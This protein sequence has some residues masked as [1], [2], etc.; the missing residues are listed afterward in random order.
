MGC[1][2]DTWRRRIETRDGFLFPLKELPIAG[3]VCSIYRASQCPV[4]LENL[5]VTL[6]PSA[7]SIRSLDS[8]L[9]TVSPHGHKWHLFLLLIKIKTELEYLFHCCLVCLNQLACIICTF[10]L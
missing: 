2:K 6:A 7:F 5:A 1:F 3:I 9:S 10:G 4:D 8:E